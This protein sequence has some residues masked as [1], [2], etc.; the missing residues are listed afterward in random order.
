VTDSDGD[1]V[2]D[3]LDYAPFSAAFQDGDQA[4]FVEAFGG[5]SVIDDSRY[6]VATGSE[7]WA[8]FANLN[9][10]LYPLTFEFGGA[11]TF[12]G[13]VPSDGSV[14]VYFRFERLPSPNVDPAYDSDPLTI[15]GAASMDYRIEIPSQG[16]NT[17]A[18]FILYVQTLDEAVDI[19]NVRVE[20]YTEAVDSD[21][22]GVPDSQDA[23]PN[24]INESVDTDGDNIGNNA[25]TDD[26]N[27]GVLD[28]QDAFPLDPAFQN[29]EQA[30]FTGLF[31]GVTLN[32]GVFE[33]PTGAKDW[34][35]F[36]NENTDLY[37]LMFEFGGQISF[38]AAVPTDVSA[39]LYFRFERLPFDPDDASATEPS[40]NT[41]NVTVSGSVPMTY[42]VDI[43][44]QGSATFSSMLM[45]LVTKDVGVAVSDVRVSANTDPVLDSELS[46]VVYHW[47]QHTGLPGVAIDV[48][49]EDGTLMDTVTSGTDGRYLMGGLDPATYVMSAS[50][51]A[52]ERDFDGTITSAD[53]LAALKIAVGLNP[54]QDPDGEGPLTPMPVSPY[55]LIAADM[56]QD[57]KVTSADAL[58]ILKRA[59][60]LSEALDP[61]WSFVDDRL[62]LWET[63]ND[64]ST[65]YDAS[66]GSSM[67]YP[68]QSEMSFVAILVG[69]VNGSW[70]SME[71]SISVE[72]DHFTKR[73]IENGAPLSIWGILDTD[74]DGLSDDQELSLGTNPDVADSDS[75][76]VN[77][78]EDAFPLDSTRSVAL[79]E[80]SEASAVVAI[81]S[82]V[83]VTQG[84]MIVSAPALL[85]SSEID[86]SAFEQPLLLR[87]DMN[88]WGTSLAFGA[89]EQGGLSLTTQLQ[90]GNYAFKVAT[91]D[92]LML[93]AG[94]QSFDS[95]M[96]GFDQEAI[97]VPGSV[98]MLELSVPN[99]GVFEFRLTQEAGD[100]VLT[101]SGQ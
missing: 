44:P 52:E 97:L 76:G 92:W 26:D 54:N 38:T 74:G 14:D 88:D 16:T 85:K 23:F 53:A 63:H 68:E 83:A 89:D 86:L 64:R 1:G 39:D 9:T 46:G 61:F 41:Q 31:D 59:V 32:D 2:V 13:S 58:A 33:F 75:D 60:K 8:G 42:T 50:R 65:V 48:E 82:E 20:A 95:R 4:Q 49:L 90:P 94:A 57:G 56:N 22:D 12:T 37:P 81:D 27:D 51:A 87:G 19:T 73:A 71:G 40:F 43:E 35:G 47:S 77:D 100:I 69:D 96:I 17:F 55:Q 67:A 15:S 28:D 34:A 36:A 21:G 6:S 25:D 3:D 62:N 70:A 79:A 18:S 93:D 24:D 29:T 66:M 80:P 78:A 11:I 84:E 98:E 72:A 7:S 91:E 99:T 45:Y 10:D 30:R 101:V 5:A